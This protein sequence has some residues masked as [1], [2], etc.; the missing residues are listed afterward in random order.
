MVSPVM[1]SWSITIP[2]VGNACSEQKV[3]MFF[4]NAFLIK[5]ASICIC[6][7]EICIIQKIKA[8]VCGQDGAR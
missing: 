8:F 5:P 4:I 1:N 2:Y 6:K 3:S 7:N